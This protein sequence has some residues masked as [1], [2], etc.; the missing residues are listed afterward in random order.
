M[1]GRC[2]ANRIADSPAIDP[3]GGWRPFRAANWA[4][5]QPV[6]RNGKPASKRA[7]DAATDGA[8][9]KPGEIRERSGSDT[10]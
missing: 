9:T 2:K 1:L 10:T 8:Q 4:A 3:L 6:G 7:A 5:N